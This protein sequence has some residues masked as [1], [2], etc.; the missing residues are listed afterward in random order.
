M[1]RTK[2]PAGQAIDSRN[3]QRAELIVITGGDTP[4]KT[5][6][7]PRGM[8]ADAMKLWR[9]YWA[10][11]IAGVCQPSE[12]WLVRRWISNFNRYQILMSAAD[13]EPMVLGSMGQQRLNPAYDLA[14]KLEASLR[15]D[16]MQLGYGP[17]NRAGL[18]IAVVEQQRTLNDLNAQYGGEDGRTDHIPEEADDED[19]R[20]AA[21]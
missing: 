5:P 2:K 13:A 11:V 15:A 12:L 20:R 16:E 10:D 18:G 1:P 9:A 4:A 7:A 8:R 3:G 17:K 21:D 19:P 14:L 6:P